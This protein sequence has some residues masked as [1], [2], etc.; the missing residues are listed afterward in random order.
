VGSSICGP[1]RIAFGLRKCCTKKVAYSSLWLIGSCDPFPL[2]FQF[3]PAPTCLSSVDSHFSLIKCLSI[4]L[5]AVEKYLREC[6][7]S[8]YEL[9]HQLPFAT[10]VTFLFLFSL[11]VS[12]ARLAILINTKV[13]NISV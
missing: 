2:T 5:G 11:A 6:P 13:G 4:S 1:Y 9:Y 7:P 8:G 12:D 10:S 3:V